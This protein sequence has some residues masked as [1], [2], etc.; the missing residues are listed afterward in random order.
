MSN[1]NGG[2]VRSLME[3]YHSIYEQPQEETLTEEQVW[4][5]VEAWVNSLIEEGYDLS[6]F[7]WEEVFQVYVDGFEQLDEQGGRLPGPA[8]RA[9]IQQ[10]NADAAAV[11]AAAL[12]AGGGQTA[13]NSA[14]MQRYGGRMPSQRQLARH[15]SGAL[16]ANRV[17][18]TGRENLFRGGGGEAAMR[19]KGLTRQQVMAQGV[20][21]MEAKPTSASGTQR[22]APAAATPPKDVIV[23]AAKGGVPGTLNK[24]TGKWTASAPATPAPT[25]TKPTTPAGGAVADQNPAA[26]AKRPSILSGLDDLKK[27]RMASQIRQK[28][29]APNIT[30]DMIGDKSI[31]APTTPTAGGKAPTPQVRA[32]TPSKLG[33]APVPAKTSATPAGGKEDIFTSTPPGGKPYGS[34]VKKDPT[35]TPY[36]QK[37]PGGPLF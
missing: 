19:D 8:R 33:A 22:P 13:V 36:G 4:E 12:K 24:T 35:G 17:A 29:G 20:R 25:G 23:K 21:N 37:R 14:L 18:A 15:S 16:T 10:R 27:M 31:K 3:A 1:L 32:Q 34:G 30:S 28:T 7:T 6:Q 2:N 11:N 9:A 26:P 5:E